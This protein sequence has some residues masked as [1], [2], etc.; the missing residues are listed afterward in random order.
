[1]MADS[2]IRGRDM[3]AAKLPRAAFTMPGV[4]IT[5]VAMFA[6]GAGRV[7]AESR[8]GEP[9][10]IA[11]RQVSAMAPPAVVTWQ[12][13]TQVSGV[14]AA[15]EAGEPPAG[16]ELHFQNRMSGNL[17]TLRTGPTG[18]F[19]IMLPQGVYDLRGKH[20]AVIASGVIVGQSPLNLGQVTPP[21]HYDVRRFFQ[22]QEVG[23]VI[24]KSPA[25]ASAYV[26]SPGEAPL[27]IAVTPI[28]SPPV[29]GAGPGGAPLAPAEVIPSEIE[30]QTQIPSGVEMPRPGMPPAQDMMPTP[31]SGY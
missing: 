5:L 15:P 7:N 8:S 14:L 12:M 9:P 10:E 6:V 2:K 25:P 11:R 13:S 21:S 16:H 23:Q 1:M 30:E 26:P 20:G 4:T 22:R 19:S 18:A 31:K 29:M 28:K 3:I 17:Y 27:P 24:V